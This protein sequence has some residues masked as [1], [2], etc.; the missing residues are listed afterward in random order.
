MCIKAQVS[1]SNLSLTDTSQNIFY[2][3]VDNTIRISGEDYNS[4]KQ[5]LA[6]LGGGGTLFKKS[7]GLYTVKVK[8]QTDDAHLLIMENHK[9]VFKKNFKVRNLGFP[10]IA[11]LNGFKDTIITLS[12]LLVNPILQISIPDCFYKLDFSVLSYKATFKQREKKTSIIVN[13]NELTE[14]HREILGRLSTGD[15][16]YFEEIVATTGSFQNIKCLPFE[17]TIK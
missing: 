6:I 1:I 7:P 9:S 2:I 11:S 14:K 10:P 3:G 8:Y 15:K 4:T 5:G 12:Q 16:I 17:I 13:K